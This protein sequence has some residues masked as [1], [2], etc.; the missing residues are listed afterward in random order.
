MSYPSTRSGIFTH[1]H[2]RFPVYYLLYLPQFN[3][4][5]NL[6]RYAGDFLLCITNFWRFLLLVG[7]DTPIPPT[8]ISCIPMYCLLYLLQF[9][10][11]TNLLR[12]AGWL[13]VRHNKFL[14][15][16]ATCWSGYTDSWYHQRRLIQDFQVT[17]LLYLAQFDVNINP[18]RY[19]DD[20]LKGIPNFW[21]FLQLVGQDK[22]KYTTN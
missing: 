1:C 20:A 5:A 7:Q 12:Y 6:L 21:W 10:V 16:F 4:P 13:F 9:D 2:L 17:H 14:V 8:K 15:I 22:Y 18:F 3:V 11:F 19:A